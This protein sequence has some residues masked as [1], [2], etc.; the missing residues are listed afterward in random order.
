MDIAH[1]WLPRLTAYRLSLNHTT[2]KPAA[3]P[4]LMHCETLGFQ[5]RV[6]KTLNFAEPMMQEEL[7]LFAGKG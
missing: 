1:S 3:D 7:V 5:Q 4:V 2:A 6:R